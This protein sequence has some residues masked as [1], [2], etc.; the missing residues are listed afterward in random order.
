M[1]EGPKH[2]PTIPLALDDEAHVRQSKELDKSIYISMW[3]LSRSICKKMTKGSLKSTYIQAAEIT[4]NF[5]KDPP[6]MIHVTNMNKFME[7]ILNR[8]Y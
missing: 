7:N 6:I 3:Q 2:D 8:S 4:L 5:M 1:W